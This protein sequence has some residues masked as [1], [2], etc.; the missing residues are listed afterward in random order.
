[1][2]KK[3]PNACAYAHI[4][5]FSLPDRSPSVRQRFIDMCVKY[6]ANHPGQVHFSVADRDVEMTRPVS[7]RDFDIAM[8]M[9]FKDKA[10]YDQYAEDGRHEE[11]ITVA[12]SISNHRRVFDSYIDIAVD[13][14]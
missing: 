13:S 7:D 10:S 1:M 5:F 9:I 11:F 12:G 4:V 14:D 2:A 8:H 6:L 3:N